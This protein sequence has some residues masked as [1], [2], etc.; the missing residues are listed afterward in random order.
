MEIP[1]PTLERRKTKKNGSWVNLK[2]GGQL[3][4]KVGNG[5]RC[6]RWC[7]DWGQ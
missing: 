1:E 7:P 5:D 6:V 4:V 3:A 2:G